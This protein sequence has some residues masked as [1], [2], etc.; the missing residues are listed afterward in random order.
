MEKEQEIQIEEVKNLKEI[1]KKIENGKIK[2]VEREKIKEKEE[3][4]KK[5]RSRFDIKD[6]IIIPLMAA[7]GI[8]AKQLI[9]PAL[10]FILRPVNI[11]GGSVAGG[12]YMMWLILARELTKKN[13]AATICAVIQTFMILMMPFGS[14]G[15]F[16]FLTYSA[17]GMA[18]DVVSFIMHKIGEANYIGYY[19]EGAVSNVTGTILVN[20]V[21]FDLPYVLL[22]IVIIMALIAGGLGGIIARGIAIEYEKLSKVQVLTRDKDDKWYDLYLDDKGEVKGD[23]FY[24]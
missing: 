9:L 16:S 6:F 13:G 11:P 17:P 21:I 7:L 23:I 14:H 8:G 20:L 5:N 19:M 2:G 18:V 24:T 12:L 22:I 3:I 15:I 10:S 4:L 1:E